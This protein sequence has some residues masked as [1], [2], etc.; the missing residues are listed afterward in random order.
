MENCQHNNTE[1]EDIENLFK[2]INGTKH[3]KFNSEIKYDS[4]T[5]DYAK[6]VVRYILDNREIVTQ[7]MVN[8]YLLALCKEFHRK[9]RIYVVNYILKKMIDNDEINEENYYFVLQ[10]LIGKKMRSLS[11]ILEV[12]IMTSPGE[13]SCAYDCYYCPNQPGMPR[14]YVAEGPSARRARQ[15][16]FDTV[17]Q[18]HERVSSYSVNGHPV[19][20]IEVIVLGGTWDSYDVSYHRKFVTEVYF[21]ANIFY[22][23]EIR[24]MKTMEEEIKINETALCKIIGL[25]IETR[26]DQINEEQI[27]RCL[28]YGVTRV[29]IGVQHTNNKILKKI[30]RQ[31]T[32]E[33][34]KRAIF[35]LKEAGLKVLTHWMPNLPGASPEI[36][37]EMFDEIN[38]NP[39]LKSD[40]IKIYPTIVTQTSD[41]DESKVYTEIEKWYIRGKY[42]PY[43][44]EELHDV[45]IHGKIH[46]HESVRIS[47]IFR[48][49]PKPNILG[50]ADEPNMRQ[51]LTEKMNSEGLECKCIRCVEVKDNKVNPE[52]IK[53]IVRE[54]DASKSKEY[55]ISAESNESRRLLHG[56][57]RLRIP[58]NKE[59]NFIDEINDCALIRELHVYGQLIPTFNNNNNI[60]NQHKGIGRK[61]IQTAEEIAYN[62]GFK[63]ISV[64]SGVG[65]RKYYEKLGYNLSQYYMIKNLNSNSNV[66]TWNI[67]SIINYLIIYILVILISCIFYRIVI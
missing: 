18:F 67:Y 37:K 60:Y 31:C 6:N 58:H 26:P 46:M 53:I 54:F 43:S 20:K 12:A 33:D 4:K 17:K 35:M 44:N 5:E 59:T 8:K 45:I 16:N 36:D 19:D 50:G 61:L 34:A 66:E 1:L 7:K 38:F 22:D 51:I 39:D 13:F 49:I 64:T 9:P 63:K 57:T 29:Q 56:F 25:T 28:S 3:I 11:G 14:S 27:K 41:K 24:E 32:I 2:K 23:T 55:F 47:R 52:N 15:S 21:A 65:V 48:D 40:D 10:F 42:I 30:N 62:N